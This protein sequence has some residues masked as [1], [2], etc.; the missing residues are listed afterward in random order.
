[1]NKKDHRISYQMNTGEELLRLEDT[2]LVKL[3]YPCRVLSTSRLNGGY[4]ENLPVVF[5]HHIPPTKHNPEDFE[6]GSV[7]AYLK[8]VVTRLGFSPRSAAGLITAARMENAALKAA[9]FRTLEVTAIVTAGIDINGGRAG[10]PAFYFEDNNQWIYVGGTINI[11]LFVNGNLL[12][13][14]LVRALITATEA[15]SAALQELMAPSRYSRGI[16]TGSGTDGIMVVSNTGSPNVFTDA[17][18]HSKLGELIGI[19]V[20]EAVTEALEKETG[21]NSSRQRNFLARLERYGVKP[22]DFWQK[23]PPEGA[24]FSQETYLKHLNFLASEEKLVALVTS[25]LHLL[26]EYRWGLLPAKEVIGAG[27]KIIRVFL[28]PTI[29]PEEIQKGKTS[30]AEDPVKDP[31]DPTDYIINL[32]INET[33]KLI[34]AEVNN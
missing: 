26:D 27:Q 15:K 5:N 2:L 9:K 8:M 21:L 33:N 18:Q 6:G 25:L 17:G 10:D 14:T 22:G 29:N 12:P 7:E 24:N 34:Q 4:Q 11:L 3:P 32:F 19:T 1:M 28:A 13:Q 16:A 30:A 23:V 20:K 31:I